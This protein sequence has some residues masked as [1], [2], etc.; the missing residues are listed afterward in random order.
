M[1]IL[2]TTKRRDAPSTQLNAPNFARLAELDGVEID[3]YG[4]RYTDN[5][6][7]LFMGYYPQVE[8]ARAANPKLAIGIVDP[9]PDAA[10]AV[11][12]ADFVVAN[13][14]E[15]EDWASAHC[16]NIFVYPIYPQLTVSPRRHVQR[17]TLVVGYHGN[18][19]HLCTMFPYVS[20]ALEALGET[21]RVELRA[22]YN[23][24]KLGRPPFDV[25]DPARVAL[26]PI[27][28]SERAYEEHLA[29]ADIG[30]VPNFIP[31]GHEA[32]AKRAVSSWPQ[33][34]KEHDSDHLLRLKSTS[35]FGRAFVFAQ[36]GV[37]VVADMFPSAAQVIRH[38][39]D[40]FL[41][42]S[43]AGWY[44]ALHQLAESPEHRQRL[45]DNMLLSFRENFAVDV[46]NRRF[47]R[48]LSELEPARRGPAALMDAQARLDRLLEQRVAPADPSRFSLVEQVRQRLSRI[49]RRVV[50]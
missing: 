5:D 19:V 2:F 15:M 1:R 40:G 4:S 37:P 45:A 44:R 3:L 10:S 7:V 14:L 27:Q 6:V 31:I 24:E 41:A 9:R 25:F 16:S 32:V 17:D 39:H 50:G 46:L 12:S 13:G 49:W 43:A 20:T 18:L 30:I 21:R 36:L 29:D 35:N 28:W 34:F 38:G 11:R 26:R 48:F 42:Y 8:A 22:V 23:V 33:V 47:V